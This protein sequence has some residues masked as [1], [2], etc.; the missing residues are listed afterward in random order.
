M[1]I[2][3]T[4]F[5]GMCN[6]QVKLTVVPWAAYCA[7]CGNRLYMLLPVLKATQIVGETL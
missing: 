6:K 5:C 3:H 4:E 7:E 1:S 2:E